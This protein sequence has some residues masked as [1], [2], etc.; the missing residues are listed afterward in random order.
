[1]N[2][3]VISETAAVTAIRRQPAGYIDL[4]LSSRAIATHSRPGQFVML[5]L[6]ERRDPILPRPF[7]VVS[8][9]PRTGTFRLIIKI[10]GRATVLLEALRAGDSLE[11]TG[12]LGKPI[13]DFTCA[14]LA[15]LVRGCGAAAVLSF[16]EE[17]KKRGIVTH[18]ILSAS[19][20]EKFILK[21]EIEALSDRLI[22]AT[23]D[24]SAGEKALGSTILKRLVGESSV[25]RI[26]SCGGG[27]FYLPDLRELDRSGRAPVWLFLESY[28]ACGF[29]HCHGCAVKK[30]GGGYS[31]VCQDGP[32]YKLADIEEPCPI[33]Q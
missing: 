33:Y 5:R 29:G 15:L 28:M 30:S 16:L 27:P 4:D 24:G 21:N 13:T 25:E 19:T 26:Y 12:P 3:T 22:L 6:P 14:S 18:T 9:S 8:T 10:A 1:V 11:I 7:D 2:N 31:L 32:L 17:T 23:D 20:A